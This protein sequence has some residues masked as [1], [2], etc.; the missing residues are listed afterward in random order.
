MPC[1]HPMRA[2]QEH[3]GCRVRIMCPEGQENMHLPCG[4][5]LGCRK[6]KAREWALRCV[7]EAAVH[8]QKCFVTLTYAPEHYPPNGFLQPA[9]LRNFLKRL[10]IAA[11]RGTHPNLIGNRVRFFA[12]GEYGDRTA[13]AHYHALLFGVD[14]ADLVEIP[15]AK[16][17][18]PLYNS[19]TL[20][21]IWGLGNVSTAPFTAR[22]AAYAAQYAMKKITPKEWNIHDDLG[23]VAPQPFVRTS[24]NPGLGFWWLWRYGNDARHGLLH[25]DGSPFS[26]PR[27]YRD[28]LK[29]DCPDIAA[30]A[31]AGALAHALAAESANLAAGES[32]ARRYFRL[33]NPRELSTL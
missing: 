27:Y 20:R 31:K 8:E 21:S 12:V 3:E 33:T 17:K 26:L 18:P 28:K 6:R 32:I 14:F 29:A 16:G 2:R 25:N 7:H 5:C 10:R 15:R 22:T 19:A 30:E 23:E 1:F 13:R 24:R 9:D 4:K 11:T